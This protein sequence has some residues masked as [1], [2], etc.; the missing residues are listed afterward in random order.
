MFDY[1]ILF[2]IVVLLFSQIIETTNQTTTT[3]L[4]HETEISTTQFMTTTIPGHYYFKNPMNVGETIKILADGFT[5]DPYGGYDLY[6]VTLYEDDRKVLYFKVSTYNVMLSSNYES[7]YHT[8]Y[9]K[10]EDLLLSSNPDDPIRLEFKLTKSKWEIYYQG[11][12]I[13][14]YDWSKVVT[15]NLSKVVT[16]FLINPIITIEQTAGIDLSEEINSPEFIATILIFIILSVTA[17]IVSVYFFYWKHRTDTLEAPAFNPYLQE[18][19]VPISLLIEDMSAI[20][21]EDP[22]KTS[23]INIATVIIIQFIC[24]MFISWCRECL[25][26]SVTTQRIGSLLAIVTEYIFSILLI[27]FADNVALAG[28][29]IGTLTIIQIVAEIIT[30]IFVESTD[31]CFCIPSVCR[32]FAPKSLD[33]NL[34]DSERAMELIKGCCAEGAGRTMIILIVLH[35]VFF[36]AGCIYVETNECYGDW[37]KYWW[38]FGMFLFSKIME[39]KFDS[40]DIE[41]WGKV[42]TQIYFAALEI[43]VVLTTIILWHNSNE[44]DEES[45][46]A[47]YMVA[48]GAFLLIYII[49]FG[50]VY[51]YKKCIHDRV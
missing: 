37:F 38:V 39:A 11:T 34:D 45:C 8:D 49:L 4:N 51:C 23:N 41:T 46:E 40:T 3:K 28:F 29:I 10:D 1:H 35:I 17:N 24:L 13:P 15:G 20:A 19:V 22:N 9:L 44:S 2:G 33:T 16:E 21:F 32:F 31:S 47:L 27:S 26:F 6:T 48:P 30:A 12:R 42:L 43:F 5:A 50:G 25:V 7:Y 14:E 36:I 18:L